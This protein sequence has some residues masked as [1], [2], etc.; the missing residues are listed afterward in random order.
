MSYHKGDD[1][2][3]NVRRVAQSAEEA[4]E[5]QARRQRRTLED[6]QRNTR[7]PEVYQPVVMPNEE[8]L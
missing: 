4:L 2:S 5:R 3:P 1:D 6:A 8:E 7:N